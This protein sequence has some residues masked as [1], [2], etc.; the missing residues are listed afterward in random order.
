MISLGLLF[1]RSQIARAG[2]R[3]VRGLIVF[4]PF[5]KFIIAYVATPDNPHLTIS[6]PHGQSASRFSVPLQVLTVATTGELG[7]SVNSPASNV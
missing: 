4:F 5:L 3:K 6:P 1:C 2:F 7:E